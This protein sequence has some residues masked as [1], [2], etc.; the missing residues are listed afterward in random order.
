MGVN[1]IIFTIGL[2][3]GFGYVFLGIIAVKHMNKPTYFDRY[4]G[5][6]LW[7]FLERD[8]YNSVGKKYCSIGMMLAAIGGISWI[9][10]F[11]KY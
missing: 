10:Y 2:V 5:W 3:C 1:F 7:W 6:S 8:K 9:L 4:I 11:V